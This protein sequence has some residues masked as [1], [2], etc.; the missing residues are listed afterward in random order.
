MS[1]KKEKNRQEKSKKESQ[2]E[3]IAVL[4]Q[5]SIE[6][7]ILPSSNK[8][9]QKAVVYRWQGIN[10]LK[11]FS[12]AILLGCRRTNPSYFTGHHLILCSCALV[13]FSNL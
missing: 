6:I 1:L 10:N 5:S 12:L 4:N 9:T 11:K 8:I 3:K 13:L 7:E 2:E